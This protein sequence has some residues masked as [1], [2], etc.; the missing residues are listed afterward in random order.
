MWRDDKDF[1]ARLIVSNNTMILKRNLTAKYNLKSFSWTTKKTLLDF[2]K[3]NKKY[4]YFKDEIEQQNAAP[5]IWAFLDPIKT[6][7]LQT[8]EGSNTGLLTF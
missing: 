6:P 2:S 5:I 3:S 8:N 7:L 1:I 4:I